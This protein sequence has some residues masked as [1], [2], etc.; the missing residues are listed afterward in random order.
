MRRKYLNKVEV[1]QNSDLGDTF[2]GN[3]NQPLQLGSSWANVSTIPTDKLVA[4]GLDIAQQAIRIQTRWRQDI[5]YFQEGIFFKYKGIEW[6][7]N[8]IYNKDLL[9]EE[10][11]IIANGINE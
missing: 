4:Y 10:I 7:P 3:L 5:D 2:S 9:N 1:W 11:V 6:F 8:R